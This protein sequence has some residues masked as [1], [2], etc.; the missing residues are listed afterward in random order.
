MYRVR[1]AITG[2]AGGAELNTMYFN[3]TTPFTAQDAADAVVAFWTSLRNYIHSTYT[4]QVETVVTTVADF[5]GVPT[6]ADVVTASAVTGNDNGDLLPPATQGLI[7]LQTGV[8]YGGRQLQGRI[9]IPGATEANSTGGKPSGAYK[10]QAD[11]AI[12]ALVADADSEL[13]VWT[14]KYLNAN[15]VSGGST[16][17][18]WAIL[19]SRRS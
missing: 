18:E 11:A 7:R 3:D 13:F 6:G 5:T 1:T 17:S 19:N 10:G 14:K 8:W 2:G 15:G 4:M 9:F 12:A 16:W